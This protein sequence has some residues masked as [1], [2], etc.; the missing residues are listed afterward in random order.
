MRGLLL[1]PFIAI[2]LRILSRIAWAGVWGIALSAA[3]I[4]YKLVFGAILAS[5]ACVLSVSFFGFDRRMAFSASRMALY[6]L[7]VAG[8]AMLVG[9]SAFALLGALTGQLEGFALVICA[10]GGTVLTMYSM[11]ILYRENLEDDNTSKG[12]GSNR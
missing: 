1:I 10:F 12:A 7:Y 11:S 8:E 9:A 2:P 6:G 3:E 4:E 5:L